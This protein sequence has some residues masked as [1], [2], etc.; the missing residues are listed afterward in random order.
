MTLI[1]AGTAAIF[2]FEQGGQAY[3]GKSLPDQVL[4]SMFPVGDGEDR[5]I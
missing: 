2:L 4:A 5:G 1:L 3:S